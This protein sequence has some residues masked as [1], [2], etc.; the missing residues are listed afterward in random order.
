MNLIVAADNKWGIGRDG[1][2]LCHLPSDMKY[3]REKTKGKVV[4]M[5]RKTFES[6]PGGKGLPDRINYVLTTNL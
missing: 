1:G 3:F 2:L 4:V 6:L 5:G